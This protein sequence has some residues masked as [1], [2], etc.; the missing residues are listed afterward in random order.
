MDLVQKSFEGQI[1]TTG[2]PMYECI[3]RVL[4][5]DA[6]AEFR[7]QASLVGSCTVVNFTT[8]MNKMTAP[9]FPYQCKSRSK[10]T[11]SKVFKETT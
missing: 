1:V 11:H 5:D 8:F 6:K 10:A 4:T 9:I 2:P 7:Q 3:K